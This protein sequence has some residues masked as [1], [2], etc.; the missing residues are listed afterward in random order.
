MSDFDYL[1]VSNDRDPEELRG[2]RNGESS[3]QENH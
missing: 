1:G 3:P 2:A